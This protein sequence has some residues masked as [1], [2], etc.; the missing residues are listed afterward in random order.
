MG[1]GTGIGQPAAAPA[2]G[3]V[4]AQAVL[5]QIYIQ[6][7][8]RFNSIIIAAPKSQIDSIEKDIHDLDKAPSDEAKAIVFKLERQQATAVANAITQFW[9]SRYPGDSP[10]VRAAADNVTN[11]VFIQASPGDMKEIEDF[12]NSVDK[13]TPGGIN[14]L[15]VVTLKNALAFDMANLLRVALQESVVSA[16]GAIGGGGVA[17]GG[18][19]GTVAATPTTGVPGSTGYAD[20][21]HTL[22]FFSDRGKNSLTV[23][24]SVLVDMFIN[25]DTRTNSLL[26][27]APE[28]TMALI[29]A[30]IRDLD[31]P[32]IYAAQVNVI[33]LKKADA[34]ALANVLS[35]MFLGTT[36]TTGAGGGGGG[37]GGA[38][39]G[40]A[41]GG[42]IPPVLQGI[43]GAVNEGAPIIDLRIAVDDRTNSIVVAGSP[44]DLEAIRII[45][46][47]LED[48]AG[49]RRM[50]KIFQLYNAQR[51]TWSPR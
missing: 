32:P 39:A 10:L 6:P 9:A 49:T 24:A 8:V 38:A 37:G 20:R 23:D 5:S 19:G 40:A 12:I 34:V 3:G 43:S 16:G 51:P 46:A 27:S 1:T 4:G 41:G 26:I 50:T 45:V 28:Q 36:I 31:V 11:S 18:I 14:V 15:R 44:N 30:V 33:Q 42:R 2:A 17:L 48:S 35:Q 29:M 22:R 47:K 7:L 25:F 21:G 13:G